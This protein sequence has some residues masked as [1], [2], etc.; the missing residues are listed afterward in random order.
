M[1]HHLPGVRHAARAITLNSMFKLLGTFFLVVSLALAAAAQDGTQY[2]GEKISDKEAL[3]AH[4][5]LQH[6]SQVAETETALEAKVNN[7]CQMKG[8]WMTLDMGNGQEVMVRF[9]DYGFF[10]PID[11]AGKTA[12]VA[13]RAYVDTVSVETLR[14]YAEDAGKPQAEID[15]ITQPEERVSFI[16]DGVIIKE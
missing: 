6:M 4:Q 11:V 9:K 15:A 16:A 5:F 13:G 2:F 1:N 10:V 14:H 3:P 12:V 8:C 7:V